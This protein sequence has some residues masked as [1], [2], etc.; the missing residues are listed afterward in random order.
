MNEI[1]LYDY[2]LPR[3]RIAQHP[4]ANRS[5]ARLMLIDR[6]NGDIAHFHIRD[7]PDLLQ[8]GDRLVTN[9]SRVVPARL[10]GFRTK[11]G[12]RWQGLFLK[13]DPQTGMW[14]MLTKTRGRLQ[15]GETITLQDG[16]ARHGQKIRVVSRTDEGHLIVQPIGDEIENPKDAIAPKTNLRSSARSI[17]IAKSDPDGPSGLAPGG[18]SPQTDSILQRY[19]RVPIPPYIRDGQMVDKDQTDY[20]TVFAKSAGSVAA[21]TA[22]LHFTDRLLQHLQAAG[23]SRSE[24]TLHVGLG[25]FRPVQSDTIAGHEMHSEWGTISP[26]T[27]SDISDTVADGGRCIAVGTTSVRVLESAALARHE[28]HVSGFSDGS[29]IER[30]STLPTRGWTDETRLFIHPGFSFRCVDAML[31]NFHLPKSTLLMLVSAFAGRELVMHAYQQAIG[32][33]GF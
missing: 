11:T 27:V 20:Q 4:V 3:D 26:R 31:T 2:E 14:E 28:Q 33:F 18:V 16:D 15:V 32:G 22:G 29:P 5:D 8:R 23:V 9:N 17:G 30:H 12:G 21:P 1:D 25:T 13:E 10:A 6:G 19:G 7:L 24:V